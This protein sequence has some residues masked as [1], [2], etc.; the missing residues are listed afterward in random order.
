M[1]KNEVQCFRHD[2]W[3]SMPALNLEKG[4]IFVQKGETYLTTG[5]P[6]VEHKKT[7]IPAQLYECGSI[8]INLGP[9]EDDY[10]H[11]AMEYVFSSVIDFEDGTFMIGDIGDG[12][13]GIYSP[14]LSRNELNAFCKTHIDRYR[15][16][17]QQHEKKIESGT[18][19]PMEKFW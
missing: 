17:F 14:R 7:V 18:A 2:Q 12:M 6:Y 3:L 16:F 13:T 4:D 1:N 8:T 10:I 5:K 19:V 9:T 15:A 11:M